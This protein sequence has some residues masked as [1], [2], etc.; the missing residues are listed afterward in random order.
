MINEGLHTSAQGRLSVTEGDIQ[1]VY[2]DTDEEKRVSLQ[3]RNKHKFHS[4]LGVKLCVSGC[5]VQHATS[6]ADVLIAYTAV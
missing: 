5:E 3:T 6:D 1:Y 2:E 4:L